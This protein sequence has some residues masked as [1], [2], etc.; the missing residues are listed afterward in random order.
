MTSFA[1]LQKYFPYIVWDEIISLTI[2]MLLEAMQDP[3]AESYAAIAN[4]AA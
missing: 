3:R 1:V 4:T 2:N